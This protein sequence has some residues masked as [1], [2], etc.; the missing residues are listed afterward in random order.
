MNRPSIAADQY[1]S[2]QGSP[3]NEAEHCHSQP[4]ASEA[5]YGADQARKNDSNC[6]CI[7]KPP[8]P[9]VWLVGHFRERMR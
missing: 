8:C 6:Q 3:N 4:L 9:C 2:R 7:G 5:S 1:T